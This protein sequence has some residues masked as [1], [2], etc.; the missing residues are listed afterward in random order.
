MGPP[1]KPQSVSIEETA[2]EQA[3]ERCLPEAESGRSEATC[4]GH[5][6]D[7]AAARARRSSAIQERN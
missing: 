6:A 2:R 5:V 1:A 4:T 3:E 7:I